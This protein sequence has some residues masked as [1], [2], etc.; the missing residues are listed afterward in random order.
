MSSTLKSSNISSGF[1]PQALL[2]DVIEGIW[3]LEI[4]F[5]HVR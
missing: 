5:E 4:N 3:F 1:F 2:E